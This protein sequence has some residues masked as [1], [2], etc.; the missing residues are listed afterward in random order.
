MNHHFASERFACTRLLFKLHAVYPE[1]PSFVELRMYLGCTDGGLAGF[2][3]VLLKE[4]LIQKQ[5]FKTKGRR[6]KTVYCLTVEGFQFA[7]RLLKEA[8][9]QIGVQIQP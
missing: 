6:H 9:S 5:A 2:V 7:E 3:K 8:Q 1:E 4:G